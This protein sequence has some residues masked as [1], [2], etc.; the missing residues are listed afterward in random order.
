MMLKLSV[1]NENVTVYYNYYT[2]TPKQNKNIKL[3][4]RC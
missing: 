2:Q 3:I 1:S 4:I